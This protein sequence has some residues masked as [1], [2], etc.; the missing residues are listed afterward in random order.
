MRTQIAIESASDRKF[1]CIAANFDRLLAINYT[2]LQFVWLKIRNLQVQILSRRLTFP[3]K[4]FFSLQ[5]NKWSP[6]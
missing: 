5:T 1:R 2:L 4:P 6:P 3:N